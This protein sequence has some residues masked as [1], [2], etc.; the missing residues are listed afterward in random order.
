MDYSKVDP[1]TSVPGETAAISYWSSTSY[2][3]NQLYAWFIYFGNGFVLF[4]SR[5]N[6]TPRVPS[7]VAREGR[8]RRHNESGFS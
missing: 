6:T 7:G 5:A 1:A 3:S 8:A 4:D 2:A